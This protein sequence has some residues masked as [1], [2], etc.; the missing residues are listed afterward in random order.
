ML[1]YHPIQRE[2]H[3]FRGGGTGSTGQKVAIPE[4]LL[5][6]YQQVNDQVTGRAGDY[7]A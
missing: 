1:N 2:R 7:R 3:I 4:P 5:G 6:T